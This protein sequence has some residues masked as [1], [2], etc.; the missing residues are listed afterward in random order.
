MKTINVLLL[1]LLV[2]NAMAQDVPPPDHPTRERTYHVVH[3][4][5]VLSV[6]VTGK[7]CAGDALIT[8]VPL[9]PLLDTVRLDAAGLAVSRVKMKDTFLASGVDGETLAIALDKPYGLDDTLVLDIGYSV[10]SPQKG[11]YFVQP[12]SGYPD[13]QWQVWTQGEAVENHYWFPCYDAPNDLSTSEMIVTVDDRYTAI[14]NGKLLGETRDTKARKRTFHW[15]EAKPHVSYLISLAV[16]NYVLV[17]DSADGVPITNYVY[18]HQA[19]D[20][21]RSF[22]KTPAMIR[23]FSSLVDYL[24]PWEKY[25]QVVIQDFMYGGEENVSISTLTDRTIHD[26]RADLDNSSVPLVAHE[27]AHQWF[28][29]LVS[30]RDWSHAW[31]SEGFATYFEMLF[32]EHEQGKDAAAKERY[33]A[34]QLVVNTDRMSNRRPTV[35]RSYVA[36]M[37]LFDSHIYQKGALVLGMMRDILGDELFTRALRA[38]VKRFA[39]RNAGT[40]DFKVAV[41]EAT[42][43][44]LEWFFDEWLYHAGYPEF[45]ISTRWDSRKRAEVVTVKQVQKVDSLTPIF[46]MP[47]DIEVWVHNRPDT[48]RVMIDNDEDTFE[49]PAYQTPQMVLFDKGSKLLKKVAFPRSMDELLFQVRFASDA[50][51]RMAAI[52]ELQWMVDSADVRRVLERVMV[53]DNA[54]FVRRD[55]AWAL[56]DVKRSDESEQLISAYG[57]RDPG[58]R[59]ASVTSL[60]RYHGEKVV[61][62]LQHAFRHDSSY[63][64]AAAALRALTT[65]DSTRRKE[66]LKEAL[67]MDSR[68]EIIRS[69]ALQRL[70]DIGDEEAQTTL[71]TYTKYGVDRNLRIQAIRSLCALWKNH[72]DVIAYLTRFLYDPSYYV[73]RATLEAL[74]DLDRESILR[75]IDTFLQK[76]HDVRLQK[77]ARDARSKIEKTLKAKN[78]H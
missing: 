37:D 65:A 5:L 33:D 58:V 6:D 31:L 64:V 46:H 24:Y 26:A 63:T 38:Y 27:L 71:M 36:P 78:A 50:I 60:G 28:G 19:N 68:D 8:L 48:Y 14:S 73:R 9:R 7:T 72:D 75:D 16:G 17:P 18:P 53:E 45:Q 74:G 47:V 49:F 25:G 32:R 12:D 77:V 10:T 66:Y 22:G 44:N 30:F 29:D 3:Y 2:Q 70:A 39:F 41:E 4:K 40:N 1:A 52:D 56:G 55:A 57:D 23:Y 34:Q 51:D 15:L 67:G 20:A 21:F 54:N 35:C 43:Y 42:G 62:I 13:K 76:E 59:A 11:M 61:S 69:T